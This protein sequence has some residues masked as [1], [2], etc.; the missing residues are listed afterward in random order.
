MPKGAPRGYGGQRVGEHRLEQKTTAVT[1][2]FVCPAG[3]AITMECVFCQVL[4]CH[5]CL[6]G[7][8]DVV[9]Q[10]LDGSR[11]WSWMARFIEMK[12]RT[13]ILND[14]SRE[15][16][17]LLSPDDLDQWSQLEPLSFEK[18]IVWVQD[19][20]QLPFVRVKT[21]KNAQS[22]RGPIHLGGDVTV[23]GYSKLT[24]DAPRDSV[25]QGYVRRVFYLKPSDFMGG[26]RPGSGLARSGLGL[27]PR[28]V[29]PGVCG[30]VS[31]ES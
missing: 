19:W 9:Q 10:V 2:N 11:R 26:E 8:R 23:V 14:G 15:V 30:E 31:H 16:I 18:S 12:T 20:E 6:A 29:L 25:S 4:V 1:G 3:A 7:H 5:H 21:V 24:P 27:D 28:T 17:R 13:R 22:R